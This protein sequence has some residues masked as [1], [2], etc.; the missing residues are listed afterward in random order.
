MQSSALAAALALF[1][2]VSPTPSPTKPFIVAVID[3][4]GR[5]LPVARFDGRRWRNIWTLQLERH[6]PVPFSNIDDIPEPWL[7][8]DVPQAWA[9]LDRDGWRIAE[10]LRVGRWDRCIS[11]V[12]LQ[13]TGGGAPQDEGTFRLAFD[14]PQAVE[15]PTGAAVDRALARVRTALPAFA[16]GDADARLRALGVLHVRG[17]EIWAIEIVSGGSAVV[18]LADIS[19]RGIRQIAL[20]DAGGC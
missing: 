6:E 15:H 4:D 13:T 14:S 9:V 20:A 10:T 3:A 18:M 5:L 1:I 7:G 11:P 17:R 19:R 2:G 16:A 12:V 8:G